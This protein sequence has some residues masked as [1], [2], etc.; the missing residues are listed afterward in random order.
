VVK[1]HNIRVII[2]WNKL[3]IGESFFVPSLDIGE[4]RREI[5]AEARLVGYEVIIKPVAY[6]GLMGVRTWRI[7]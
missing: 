6:K 5:A 4:L 1:T 2:S 3:S 7:R